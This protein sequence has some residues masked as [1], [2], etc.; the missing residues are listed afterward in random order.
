MTARISLILGEARGHRPRLQL[1]LPVLPEIDD[2]M[3]PSQK[4]HKSF[5]IGIREPE[6]WQHL[7]IAATCTLEALPDEMLHMRAGDQPF[8]KRP[9]DRIPKISHDHVFDELAARWLIRQQDI[10]RKDRRF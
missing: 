8:G 10:V 6:Q 9:G 7:P 1:L 2:A 3:M 4:V 5:V